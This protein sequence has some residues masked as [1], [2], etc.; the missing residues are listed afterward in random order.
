MTLSR[1]LIP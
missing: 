1:T